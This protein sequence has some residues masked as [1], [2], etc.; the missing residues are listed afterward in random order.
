MSNFGETPERK[1]VDKLI[2][3]VIMCS[4]LVSFPENNNLV[5]HR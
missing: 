5:K 1:G 2:I 4:M 3:F